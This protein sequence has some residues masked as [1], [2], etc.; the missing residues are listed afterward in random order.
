MKNNPIRSAIGF[1]LIGIMCAV[2]SEGCKTKSMAITRT[3]YSPLLIN[4]FKHDTVRVV[5]KHMTPE[6]YQAYLQKFYKANFETLMQPEFRRLNGIITQQAASIQQLSTS[7]QKLST[8]IVNMR[9]RALR[10]QDSLQL[11]NADQSSELL[12][13]RKQ[14]VDQN[15]LQIHKLNKLTNVLLIVGV[16]MIFLLLILAGVVYIQWRRINNLYKNL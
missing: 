6:E 12:T 13:Y 11:V 10:K 5:E 8:V 16:T 2:A 9:S 15:A 7:T 14:Q 3:I 1:L 4:N